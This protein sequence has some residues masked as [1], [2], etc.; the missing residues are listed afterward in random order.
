MITAA[1]LNFHKAA[2]EE[3]IHFSV[4]IE[5][6]QILG[7]VR[8]LA[9]ENHVG[10]RVQQTEELLL[11]QVAH[12]ESQEELGL[13]LIMHIEHQFDEAPEYENE[14]GGR[15]SINFVHLDASNDH[16]GH[17]PQMANPTNQ[18]VLNEAGREE[19]CVQQIVRRL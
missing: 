4:S 6:L 11:L 19:A 7:L 9:Q 5:W 14:N 18:E 8:L 1:R 17:Q 15:T 10:D 2:P 12:L 3:I 13:C 16:V